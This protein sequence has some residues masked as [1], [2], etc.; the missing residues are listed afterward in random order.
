MIAQSVQGV[1][2]SVST[3]QDWIDYAKGLGIFLVVYGHTLDSTTHA[4]LAHSES[5]QSLS[6]ATFSN[7]IPIFFFLS[8]LFV[9]RSYDKR[10]ALGLLGDRLSRLAYPYLVWSLLQATAE[11]VFPGASQHG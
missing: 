11:I 2:N 5:F 6:G 4:G 10:R 3:R 7:L 1:E 8:G 9:E